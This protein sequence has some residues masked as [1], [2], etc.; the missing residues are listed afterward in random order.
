MAK[1]T[2]KEERAQLASELKDELNDI[3]KETSTFDVGQFLAKPDLLPELGDIQIYDYDEEVTTCNTKAREVMNGL[4]K[5]Y[6]GDVPQLYENDY[7]RLKMEE[8]IVIYSEVLFLQRMSKKNYIGQLRQIDN[9][10]NNTR[11]HEV[12]NR[13]S[14][15]IRENIKFAMNIKTDFEN[16]YMKIREDLGVM[17]LSESNNILSEMKNLPDEVD[18][19]I[20]NEEADGTILDQRSIN[21]M[22]QDVIR[23]QKEGN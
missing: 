3:V 2:K 11:M 9:G 14:S 17:D 20:D 15:E 7:I 8:D 13:T 19:D 10:D 12:V 16:Y 1:K 5:L 18:S 21:S 6:L 22:I 4:V 23:Q